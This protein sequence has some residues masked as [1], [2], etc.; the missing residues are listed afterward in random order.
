M[1]YVPILDTKINNSCEALILSHGNSTAPLAANLDISGIGII[2]SFVLSAYVVLCAAIFCWIFNLL[3]I[4]VLSAYDTQFCKRKVF[5]GERQKAYDAFFRTLAV[6]VL[7]FSDTQILQGIAILVAAFVN[8]KTLS[9]FDWQI[10]CYLGWMSSNVHLTTLLFMQDFLHVQPIILTIRVIGMLLLLCLLLVA[11]IPTSTWNWILAVTRVY[12]RNNYPTGPD[13]G[14]HWYALNYAMP[15]HC[16]WH[17]PYDTHGKQPLGFADRINPDAPFAYLALMITYIWR[18]AILVR[19]KP[20]SRHDPEDNPEKHL[21]PFGKAYRKD[22]E[23]ALQMILL[24]FY[25]HRAKGVAVRIQERLNNGTQTRE[26]SLKSTW[27]NTRFRFYCILY[28]TTLAIFDFFHSFVASL[29][30]LLLLLFWGT[31]EIANMRNKALPQVHSAL[32]QWQFGQILPMI[33]LAIPL[34]AIGQHFMRDHD[35][36]KTN[37]DEREYEIM[38]TAVKDGKDHVKTRMKNRRDRLKTLGLKN[39]IKS[40]IGEAKRYFERYKTLGMS[41]DENE[42]HPDV[43]L[44]EW[45][46]AMPELT[47]DAA[48]DVSLNFFYKDAFFKSLLFIPNIMALVGGIVALWLEGRSIVQNGIELQDES[49][50]DIR[51]P[52]GYVFEYVGIIMAAALAFWILWSILVWFLCGLFVLPKSLF[53]GPDKKSLVAQRANSL[54]ALP[55]ATQ[56][57]FANGV[58]SPRRPNPPPRGETRIMS[59]PDLGGIPDISEEQMVNLQS[60]QVRPAST[61]ETAQLMSTSHERNDDSSHTMNHDSDHDSDHERNHDSIH[62]MDHSKDHVSDHDRDHD[63]DVAADDQ[64][65]DHGGDHEASGFLANGT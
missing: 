45:F 52:K 17:H 26:F 7:A 8:V 55:P 40:E 38:M 20:K 32:N 43:S 56:A 59:E 14:P 58:D 27:Y 19:N 29:W 61:W 42:H 16:F 39:A 21:T 41:S 11:F 62:G 51:D 57:A 25:A 65:S 9:V 15:A 33:L 12:D 24:K 10:V 60:L 47:K 2:I 4:N 64:N 48:K 46:K 44:F 18:I 63:S 54:T 23:Y 5:H 53:N 49:R 34:L 37:K 36:H 13:I 31:F 30:I 22:M 1:A 3:P 28:A 35:N 6:G 50:G